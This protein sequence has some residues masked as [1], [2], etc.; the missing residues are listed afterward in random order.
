MQIELVNCR[1]DPSN[2]TVSTK[3]Y[4]TELLK[5]LKQLQPVA[6]KISIINAYMYAYIIH[7]YT[8]DQ[9][10]QYIHGLHCPCLAHVLYTCIIQTAE[11]SCTMYMYMYIVVAALHGWALQ[12]LCWKYSDLCTL[13]M[14]VTYKT[15]SYRPVA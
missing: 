3:H 2:A 10:V 15:H 14:H 13:G 11:L 8:H 5:S 12:L 9:Y 1:Q 4:D 7:I 6:H